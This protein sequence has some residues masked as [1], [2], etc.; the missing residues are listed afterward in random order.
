MS[1]AL[2]E[3]E[4]V[5]ARIYT[6]RGVKVMLD[7][8]L[9]DLYQVETRRLNEQ[10][11]RNIDRFP[12]D[13]MFQLSKNEV[14]SLRSQ[15]AIANISTKSRALPHVFTEHGTLMLA[16]VLTSDIAVKVNQMIIRAF[17]E[18]RQMVAS[19]PEYELL[20]EK[21]RRIESRVEEVAMSQK[22]DSS[23]VERKLSSMSTEIRNIS[24]TLDGFQDGYILINRPEEGI[25]GDE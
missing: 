1:N 18:L 10:V 14:E 25:A 20:K 16:S 15:N 6:I 19:N 11:K 23:V 5:K 13:F 12:S 2:A 7:R 22:V 9:A 21:I 17:V 3:I 8:D 4:A 24:E